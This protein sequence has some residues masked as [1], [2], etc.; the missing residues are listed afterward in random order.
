MI[1]RLFCI[2]KMGSPLFAVSWS[3][4]TGN[5]E[6]TRMT[7]MTIPFHPYFWMS[8]NHR[9]HSAVFILG[10]ALLC[11][12]FNPLLCSSTSFCSPVCQLFNTHIFQS[13]S[14]DNCH[15]GRCWAQHPPFLTFFKTSWVIM[16]RTIICWRWP[17][18]DDGMVP[19]VELGDWPTSLGVFGSANVPIWY[20]I[21]AYMIYT[22]ILYTHNTYNTDMIH[23]YI[24]Y[25][26]IQYKTRQDKTRQDKTRQYNT[27][28]YNTYI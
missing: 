3:N 17:L 16:R 7:M 24:Q 4:K 12:G 5:V 2:L 14:Q 20:N 21:F 26:T 8:W 10:F 15:V 19:S 28:Q 13:F 22:Y 9:S 23:T 27:I 25:N 1:P 6:Q 18:C 11:Q